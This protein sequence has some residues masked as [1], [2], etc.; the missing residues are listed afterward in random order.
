[1][2]EQHDET[3]TKGNGNPRANYMTMSSEKSRK[4]ALILC[5]VLGMLG[6]HLFYV[7]RITK[8]ILYLCTGGLCMVGV[9]CDTISIA[10]GSFRDNAGAPLRQW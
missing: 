9:I 6:G 2:T 1:M 7:G 4:L 5:L 3:L 8:G 10:T